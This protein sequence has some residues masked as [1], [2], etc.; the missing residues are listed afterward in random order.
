MQDYNYSTWTNGS[1]GET[2]IVYVKLTHMELANIHVEQIVTIH[3]TRP[4]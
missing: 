3:Q 2:H 4:H 1:G